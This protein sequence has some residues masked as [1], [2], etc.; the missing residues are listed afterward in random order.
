VEEGEKGR[1]KEFKGENASALRDLGLSATAAI[2]L[3]RGLSYYTKGDSPA[4]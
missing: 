1:K 4:S 2:R 3:I